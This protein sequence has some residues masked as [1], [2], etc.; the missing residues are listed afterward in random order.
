MV[1]NCGS[2]VADWSDDGDHLPSRILQSLPRMRFPNTL[3]TVTS[4][5]RKYRVT[6][7]RPLLR[8]QSSPT[9]NSREAEL[10]C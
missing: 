9:N 6:I 7:P 1:S 5:S 8:T 3:N 10:D 4:D 2:E